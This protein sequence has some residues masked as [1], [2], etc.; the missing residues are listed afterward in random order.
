MDFKERYKLGIKAIRNK[1][2]I[3]IGVSVRATKF[4]TCYQYIAQVNIV[5]KDISLL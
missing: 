5:A 4:A 2:F 1:N 3:S